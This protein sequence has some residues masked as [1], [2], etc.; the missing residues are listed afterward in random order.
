MKYCMY[1]AVAR[2]A[3]KD[4]EGSGDVSVIALALKHKVWSSDPQNTRKC[5]E[6]M[7]ASL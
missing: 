1:T 5:W 2:K 4:L 7:V 3:I 6:S